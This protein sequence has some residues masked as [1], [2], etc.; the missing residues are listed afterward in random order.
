M[1]NGDYDCVHDGLRRQQE[2]VAGL[3][4][5]GVAEDRVVFLGYPDGGLGR[6][7]RLPLGA[8][9]LERGR[10][11]VGG[12][13]Y[14]AR[15]FGGRDYH[16]LRFG[17]GAPYTRTAAV[18]D[19]AAVI[20]EV[21][22]TDVVVTH[23]ADTHPDHAATYAL[24][25]SAIERLPEPP[26]VHRAMVHN[27]DCW[28][29]GEGAG[30]PCPPGGVAVAVPTPPLTGRLAGYRA[31]E[32]WPVPMSCRTTFLDANPKVRAIAAHV[33]QTRGDP[34]SYLFSF[35]RA[36]ELFFP[37]TYRREARREG[38]RWT[39]ATSSDVSTV[40][41]VVRVVA[42]R[43]V[44][45]PARVAAIWGRY[46][47]DVDADRG[48]A[49]LSR[50]EG[51]NGATVALQEW[52]LSHDLWSARTPEIFELEVASRSPS[53]Q[54]GDGAGAFTEVTLRLRDE[55]VGVAVDAQ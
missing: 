22:P 42:E 39:V 38:R 48:Q 46:R 32:R 21:R 16:R 4:A 54:E 6:L 18:S 14:G 11:V 2:S 26:R 50:T 27:G 5:L 28:P 20:S 8:R 3:A 45:V 40:S 24:F 12:A 43:P 55:I 17:E 35:A 34:H 47:L 13:T 10:C 52:P 51:T 29:T 33:S 41:G 19:L 37:E 23:G 7:G 49:T 36:D 31:R 1:T 25:R 9:R 30:P 44:A 53:H 15:G